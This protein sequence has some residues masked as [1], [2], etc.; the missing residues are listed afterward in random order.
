MRFLGKRKFLVVARVV[1]RNERPVPRAGGRVAETPECAVDLLAPVSQ[2][3]LRVTQGLGRRGEPPREQARAEGVLRTDRDRGP[4]AL[5]GYETHLEPCV[6]V[7]V[8]SVSCSET[9]ACFSKESGNAAD[10]RDRKVDLEPGKQR[11]DPRKV[12]IRPR[13]SHAE[14]QRYLLGEKGNR[15]IDESYRPRHREH[16]LG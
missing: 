10:S 14:A 12:E 4:P 15:H 11:G 5:L 9:G 3:D 16:G 13:V 2:R 1:L 7:F 6:S 8:G